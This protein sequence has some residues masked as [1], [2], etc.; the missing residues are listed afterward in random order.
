MSRPVVIA[1]DLEH[2]LISTAVS[3]IPRAGLAQF[4]EACRRLA[5]VVIYTSVRAD[6]VQEIVS[7]LVAE[8]VAPG[9]FADVPVVVASDG[10]KDLKQVS[11]EAPELVV[12]VDDVPWILPEAQRGQLVAIAPF[13]PP[14]E[15]DEELARIATVLGAWIQ[16]RPGS[17]K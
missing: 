1:L 7:R 4:L 9:W 3:Q 15:T 2:T 14:Y 10:M 12:L 8:G 11:V 13:E 6:R 17:G 16:G 5:T